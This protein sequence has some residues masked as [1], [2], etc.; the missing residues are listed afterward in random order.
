MSIFI[1]DYTPLD[2]CVFIKLSG[3][4]IYLYSFQQ[5]CLAL[6]LKRSN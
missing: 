6:R 5:L 2:Q 3:K 4:W 1:V